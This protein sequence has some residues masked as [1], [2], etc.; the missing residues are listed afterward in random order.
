MGRRRVIT[1]SNGNHVNFGKLDPDGLNV[2][3]YSPDDSNSNLR[4]VL[5]WQ[6]SLEF[7]YSP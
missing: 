5:F 3:N 1:D 6:F 7:K 4:V 2:N